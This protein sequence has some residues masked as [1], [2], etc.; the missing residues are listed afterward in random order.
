[1]QPTGLRVKTLSALFLLAALSCSKSGGDDPP[2]DPCAGKNI[3]VTATATDATAPGNGSI[4]VTATGSTGFTFNINNGA[5]GSSATFSNLAA[6]DYTISAKDNAGCTRST[7]VRVNTADACAGKTITFT[8]SATQSDKCISGGSI[9]VTAAGSTGFQYKL[10]S[11]G[12]YG[13]TGSFASVAA[14]T[15]T[16][17]ARDAAGCEKTT[18]VV[19]AEKPAG[20]LY[21]AARNLLVQR[22]S[23]CHFGSASQGGAS[24]QSDCNMVSLRNRIKARA[25]D[26]NSMPQGGPPLTADEKKIITDWINAGGGHSN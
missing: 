3:V 13:A 12:T 24:F 16:V 8:S 17:F 19:V 1:M 23:S 25:V 18:Q 11:T 5:F 22:C 15:Y 9:T 10:N 20:S 2:A 26:D 14:G 21:T 4:T 6:G 7:T